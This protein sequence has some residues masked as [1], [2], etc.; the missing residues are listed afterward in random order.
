MRKHWE[1]SEECVKIIK[2]YFGKYREVFDCVWKTMRDNKQ[3]R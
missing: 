1:Y 3:V 2:E